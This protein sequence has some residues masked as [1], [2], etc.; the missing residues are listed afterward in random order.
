MPYLN[1]LKIKLTFYLFADYAV[2]F[3]T[4]LIFTCTHSCWDKDANN[5]R[6]EQCIVQCEKEQFLLQ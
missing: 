6:T 3:G 4:I 2:E 1:F 5:P